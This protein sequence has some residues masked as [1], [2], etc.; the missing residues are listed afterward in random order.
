MAF[1]Q[2]YII[3]LDEKNSKIPD[4]GARQKI[5]KQQKLCAFQKVERSENRQL[6]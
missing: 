2:I 4:S 5:Y 3:E 6:S 1:L